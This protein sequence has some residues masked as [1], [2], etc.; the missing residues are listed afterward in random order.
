MGEQGADTGGLT[1]EYFRLVFQQMSLKYMQPS[2]CFKH[3][4]IAYQVSVYHK[5]D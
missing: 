5:F 4:S 3:D 2:G 1:R